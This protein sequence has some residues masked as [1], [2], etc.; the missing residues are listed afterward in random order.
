MR[1]GSAG[2]AAALVASVGYPRAVSLGDRSVRVEVVDPAED[3]RE[4]I[5][6][7][8][9]AMRREQERAEREAPVIAAAAERRAKRNA[10]RAAIAARTV[11]K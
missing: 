6:A 4:R 1:I 11:N 2:L 9:R 3:E 8:A 10:K 7:E 5:E